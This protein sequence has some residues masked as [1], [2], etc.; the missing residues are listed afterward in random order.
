MRQLTRF[1][2]KANVFPPPTLTL[3]LPLLQ[4]HTNKHKHTTSHTHKT[5]HHLN[6]SSCI[7]IITAL[8][9]QTVPLSWWGSSKGRYVDFNLWANN[10]ASKRAW[11]ATNSAAKLFSPICR[12]AQSGQRN[13]KD[14]TCFCAARGMRS[15]AVEGDLTWEI[16]EIHKR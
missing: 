7:V 12:L 13:W 15:F 16:R 6:E 11:C 10:S 14:Q 5:H 1:W 4:I 3:S 2:N 9:A 8:L